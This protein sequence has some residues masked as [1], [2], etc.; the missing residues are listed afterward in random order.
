MSAN[1]PQ[2]DATRNVLRE[3]VS[4]LTDGIIVI[5]ADG[6]ISWANTSALSMHR[7]QAIEELGGSVAKYRRRF[8]L[9]YRNNHLLDQGQYPL[10]RL[11]AGESFDSVTVEVSPT[12]DSDSKWVHAACGLIIGGADGQPALLALILRDETPLFEAEERFERSFNANPAPGLICRLDDHCFIRVN[13]GF[14]EMTGYTK[15]D[16]IGKTVEALGLFSDCETGE[17]ALS[18]LGEGRVIRHREALV[19]LPGGGDRMVMVAGEPIAVEE[20]PCMLFTFADLDAR[21]RAQNALRQSEE[22]FSKSFR[23]SPSASAITRLEDFAFIE[24][25]A[26]FLHLIGLSETE[27]LGKA[28]S[29]VHLFADVVERRAL[30]RLLRDN[31]PVQ[32]VEAR[33][34]IKGDG[35][36]DCLVSAERVEMNDQQTVIWSFQDVT[37]RK[38]TEDELVEAIGAVMADT[39]WFGRSIVE[40]LAAIRQK[41][42]GKVSDTRLLDLTERERQILALI[43]E[44]MSDTEMAGRVNLSK[45]TIRNHVSSL[46]AK[47]GVNRRTAAVAWARDRGFS[48]NSGYPT[49]K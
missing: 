11:A 5:E 41:S 4:S 15:E 1:P 8:S 49:S 33:I 42:K 23:L 30:E 44:G 47:I 37:E 43:C 40:R 46:Y 12:N 7:I 17:E 29:D 31:E 27:L 20:E 10:E 13:Q 18:K 3:L 39:S 32:N 2:L 14:I 9:R 28:P 36:A 24:A 26:A 48:G 38:R 6:T 34:S 16:V 19:P 35:F 21:R 45:N 22:R 25:N